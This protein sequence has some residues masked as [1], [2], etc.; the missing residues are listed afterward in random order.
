MILFSVTPLSCMDLVDFRSYMEEFWFMSL[1]W[2]VFLIF[3]L[4][5]KFWFLTLY[6]IFFASCIIL[7]AVWYLMFQYIIWCFYF[8]SYVPIYNRH[9][10]SYAMSFQFTDFSII[11]LWLFSVADISIISLLLACISFIIHFYKLH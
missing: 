6:V 11:P 5:S 7:F 2:F 3:W 4:P 1:S 9:I 8:R 10:T